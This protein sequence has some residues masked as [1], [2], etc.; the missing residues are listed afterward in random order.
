MLSQLDAYGKSL[1]DQYFTV[2]VDFG[3]TVEFLFD[4]D[5]LARWLLKLSFNSGRVHGTDLPFLTKFR[6]AISW[7]AANWK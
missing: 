3:D 2:P 1:Y 6:D 4:F 7:A 5:R